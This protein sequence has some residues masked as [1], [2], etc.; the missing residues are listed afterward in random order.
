MESCIIAAGLKSLSGVALIPFSFKSRFKSFLGC[1]QDCTD[2]NLGDRRELVTESRWDAIQ[3]IP[4][5]AGDSLYT[6]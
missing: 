3:I 6:P 2:F 4:R 5:E 1:L